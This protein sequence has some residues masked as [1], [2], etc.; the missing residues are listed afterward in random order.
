MPT[1]WRTNVMKPKPSM[2]HHWMNKR[3]LKRSETWASPAVKGWRLIGVARRPIE[4]KHDLDTKRKLTTKKGTLKL[5]E[6]TV[7]NQR[8][9]MLWW[10]TSQK[11]GK[12]ELAWQETHYILWKIHTRSLPSDIG[13]K[14]CHSKMDYLNEPSSSDAGALLGGN[15]Y[16][17][18]RF[19]ISREKFH[20]NECCFISSGI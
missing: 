19:F 18:R 12:E 6:S 16:R 5:F 13:Q 2:L 20:S 9:N 11:S 17:W 14:A 4:D 7:M 10:T 3:Q 15:I 1:K 8:K